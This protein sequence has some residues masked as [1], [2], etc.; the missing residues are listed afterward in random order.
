MP[1]FAALA[2]RQG[3]LIRKPL[4]GIIAVAED[5]LELDA[6]FKLTTLAAG[7][8]IELTELTDW[9]QL[10]WVSKSDGVVFSADTETSDVES[11]GALEPTRSDIT[12]DV[13]SAQFTC[14]ETNKKVL[15]MFYNVDLSSTLGDFETGEVDFNQAVEPSTT[16]RRMLFLSKDGSGPREVFIGKLMPRANVSA[17]SDQSWNSEDAL[18]HGMTITA[19]V[20]DEMGYA[21]RHMFGGEGWKAQITKMGF[22]LAPDPDNP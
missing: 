9:D 21:V 19:K 7:G 2:K 12:K 20:D 4:A 15:E 11:W 3:E 14:Q 17:K 16:Y 18:T 1:S 8:A 5:T 22:A 13:T 6:D 10:G